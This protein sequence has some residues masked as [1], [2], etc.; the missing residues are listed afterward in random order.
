VIQD[1]MTHSSLQLYNVMGLGIDKLVDHKLQEMIA[2]KNY[3]EFMKKFLV[4][5]VELDRALG[6]NLAKLAMQE[7]QEEGNP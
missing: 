7:N 4:S 5:Q 3:T 6:G 1:Q 2:Y